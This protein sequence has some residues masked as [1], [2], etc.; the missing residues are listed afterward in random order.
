VVGALTAEGQYDRPAM[1]AMRDAAGAMEVVS[2]RAFDYTTD[3]VAA[4]EVLIEMGYC[5]VLSSGQSA[6]AYEGRFLLQK[7]VTQATDRITIMPGAGISIQNIREIA[8][9]TG[10]TALHLTARTRIEQPAN[11]TIA[12]LEWGFWTS[13][14]NKI[15]A[16]L[17][18]LE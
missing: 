4:L 14:V 5:R 3:P 1:E 6:T 16:V 9:V 10:A 11:T 7:M 15:R 8:A 17:N 13:D 2:H 18:A 12:G